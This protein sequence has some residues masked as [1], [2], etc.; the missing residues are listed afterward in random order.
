MHNY[1]VILIS[2]KTIRSWTLCKVL[3]RRK[4]IENKANKSYF[5]TNFLDL[6]YF[7]RN[8]S[9][10]LQ[11]FSPQDL[12]GAFKC[13]QDS[14]RDGSRNFLSWSLDLFLTRNGFLVL[15][16]LEIWKP[17]NL[18][19]SW[20]CHPFLEFVLSWELITEKSC[21][22]LI[23]T[24]YSWLCLVLSWEFRELKILVLSWLSKFCLDPLGKILVYWNK[25]FFQY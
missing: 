25:C 4:T 20:F 3:R 21:L 2:S 8:I 14:S 16:C 23:L 15:S 13:F 22:V 12:I 17:K 10:D 1:L 5:S 9:V 7:R 19:L 6:V 11:L 24:T 18:V